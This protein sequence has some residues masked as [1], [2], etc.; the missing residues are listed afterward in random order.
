MPFY[1]DKRILYVKSYGIVYLI[2]IK[3]KVKQLLINEIFYI[4]KDDWYNFF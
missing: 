3:N 4:L 1:I 2:S